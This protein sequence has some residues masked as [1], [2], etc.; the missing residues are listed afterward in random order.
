[1]FKMKNMTLQGKV[2]A[3][4]GVFLTFV[5]G[6]CLLFFYNVVRVEVEK[7]NVE[8][9]ASY[10]VSFQQSFSKPEAEGGGMAGLAARVSDFGAWPGRVTLIDD[11]GAVLYDSSGSGAE[12]M[13]NHLQRPEIRSALVG[14]TGVSL[15]Y[16]ATLRTHMH[17]YALKTRDAK[18]K[19]VFIRLA[20]PISALTRILTSF[21]RRSAAALALV[22]VISLFFWIWLAKRLFKPLEEVVRRSR[23]IG[24]ADVRFPIFRDLELQR[25][26]EAL[27]T[28]SERLREAD[29]DIR[30]RR[31][32]LARIIEALPIGIVLMDSARKV[33][34]LNGVTRFL[35]GDAGD[36]VKGSPVERLI[37]NGEIY[38][39]LDGPDS[40][41][42]VFLIPPADAEGGL[43]VEVSTI[44]LAT[45][46][47][48]TLRDV[49]EERRLEE[50]RRNFTIDAGHELQTPLTAIRAA[51]ELLMEE[52]DGGSGGDLES[53]D[54]ESEDWESG[55]SESKGKS[56]KK[57]LLS[58]ILRQQ[59]R[60]TS[61][62]DD[63]LLLVK[64]SDSKG[65]LALAERTAEDLV[66]LLKT[67]AD[68]FRDNPAARS[69]VI[70]TTAVPG[71][72][73]SGAPF[74][75]NRSELLRAISNIVDNAVRKLGEK[76]GTNPGGR[77]KLDL[78]KK[79]GLWV[80][81][82][83]D[84]GPGVSLEVAAQISKSFRN[85]TRTRN[86]G[87]WGSGG[88]GLG[89]S[90]AARVIES[91]GGSIELLSSSSLGGA[92]FEIRL[93]ME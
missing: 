31:E 17:Y 77:V 48:M 26:S 25:L 8:R 90:I 35:F 71:D 1:M 6:L 70:E 68:E 20:Y 88:H 16:S 55:G 82:V 42:V 43:M 87:K 85:G 56:E 11:E 52:L 83:A 4:F 29:A 27:N 63:L 14:G 21:L 75:A 23:Q 32:E 24:T 36:V 13:D 57:A 91:H 10:A 33:R 7:D 51:A 59:E 34:Y 9:M 12:A 44:S 69:V 89:L 62:I 22:G 18:G 47:L 65:E 78:R 60:M 61:L 45:G 93:P 41:G 84:N 28:M 40:S 3:L 37:P 74:R 49:T 67:V 73:V 19:V 79:D 15:R 58:T 92:D 53:K 81:M 38:D 50:T 54:S 39:M 86:R 46:R 66:D 72:G 80:V 5:P 2:V 30:T 64:L 76:Y